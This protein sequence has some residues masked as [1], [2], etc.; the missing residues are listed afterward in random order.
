M[1]PD[2]MINGVSMLSLGWLRETVN[3]PTPQSQSNTITVPGRNSPSRFTEALGRVTYQPRSFDMTFSMLGDRA[4]FDILVSVV[5]NQFAGKLCRV[6]MTEDLTLYAV[7]AH[8]TVIDGGEAVSLLYDDG[9]QAGW[10]TNANYGSYL[11]LDQGKTLSSPEINLAGL[12]SIIVKIRTYG[13]KSYNTL[14]VTANETKLTDIVT[15][16]GSTMTEYTWVNDQTLSGRAM[17]V[18]SSNYGANKG[19]GVQS[20]RIVATGTRILYSDFITFCGTTDI[21]NRESKIEN[22]KLL[23]NGQLYI[24][25]GETFYTITGQRVSK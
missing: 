13:G 22:R 10:Q 19:I 9:H 14:I 8:K 21:E 6:T 23:I 1:K 7:F 12:D 24:R 18:F 11:L 17:I 16:T 4:D 15:T 25:V 5:V 3:F 20:V 2:A